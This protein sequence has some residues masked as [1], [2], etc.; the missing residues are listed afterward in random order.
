MVS[1][2]VHVVS[3]LVRACVLSG[4]RFD[5]TFVTVTYSNFT[6][7]N[8]PLRG[9]T[10]RRSVDASGGCLVSMAPTENPEQPLAAN[11]DK[12]DAS[13]GV[14]EVPMIAA[15]ALPDAAQ[16]EATITG[17]SAYVLVHCAG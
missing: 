4:L 11:G 17:T 16:A 7:R 3:C 12:G 13:L 2:F 10:R 5:V 6:V 14:P 8:P 9:D 1:P 15:D